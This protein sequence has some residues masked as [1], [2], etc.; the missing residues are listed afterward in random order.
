MTPDEVIATLTGNLFDVDVTSVEEAT[1]AG[2]ETTLVSLFSGLMPRGPRL[3][4][5]SM[6]QKSRLE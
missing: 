5:R 4:A 1:V 3:R 2:L 6:P